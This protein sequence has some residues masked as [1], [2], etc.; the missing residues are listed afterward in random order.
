[1][2]IKILFLVSIIC[3]AVTATAQNFLDKYLTDPL[4]YT[5]IATLSDSIHSPRD[6]DFKPGTNELWIV[7]AGFSDGG[8][9]VIIFNAGLS[10]Q[11]SQYRK[12]THTSHFMGNPSAL[13]FNDEGNWASSG[14]IFS[15]CGSNCTFMGP[16]LWSG[17]TNIFARVFQNNW[18][19][20]YPLGSHLDML[21]QSPYAMGIASDSANGFWVFDGHNG[22]L[23]RYDFNVDHGPGHDDHSD[24]K[25]RRYIDILLERTI[26]VPGH[27]AKDKATGWLYIAD[28][29]NNRVIRVNT[30]TGTLGADLAPASTG[31]ETLAEY[32]A[33]T[34]AVH[35]T[36]DSFAT[37]PCGIDVYNG[38]LIIGDHDNGNIR[39][40]DITGANP[41]YLGMIATGQSGI[42]G[43]KIGPDGK[44]WFVNNTQ[45][46]V[47]R[48]NPQPV[49]DDASILNITSPITENYERNFYSPYFDNCVSS[50]VPAVTLLNSGSNTLT[51]VTINYS[52]DGTP[53]PPFPW[54]GSLA[55]GATAPVTLFGFTAT[56]GTHKIVVST[57][58]PNG[59]T[60]RNPANDSKSGSFRVMNPVATLP[61]SQTFS[62]ATFPPSGWSYVNYNPDNY[63]QRIA[64]LGGFGN[65]TG[66]LKMDIYNTPI[67]ITG[68]KD[69]FISP[70]IDLSG[71]QATKLIFSVA[72]AQYN[73]STNDTLKVLISTDCGS[74]WTVLYNKSGAT[75]A[76]SPP[77]NSGAFT[78]TSSQWR[79]DTISLAAYTGQAEALFMFMTEANDGNNIYLDDIQIP[80]IPTSIAQNISSGEL[81]VYPNPANSNVT[82]ELTPI[83]N[84]DCMVDVYNLLGEKMI[85]EPITDFASGKLNL[86]LSGLPAGNYFLRI[87]MDERISYT[88][89]TIVK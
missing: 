43:V 65:N 30:L 10:N 60:D 7:N 78:P 25:I 27:M 47:V 45:N 37:R 2:K 19:N 31:Y 40:Y 42:E 57:S 29:G 88:K 3:C 69:Y 53:Y 71:S 51:S 13:A 44:I 46:T 63:M 87:R 74:S 54:S 22:D 36:V 85:S 48:I 17:D 11:T 38:R 62:S 41:V 59:T 12:D 4:T 49:V 6:L 50:V 67:Y 82:V 68:Q 61:F 56:A 8:T 33:V 76:T 26:N 58:N 35:Q 84:H 79:S 70:R 5:T 52:V 80:S 18:L 34:G 15:T 9:N 28:N 14:E 39:I 89:L 77:Y 1:M 66:C 75:L 32:K 81:N 83:P 73:S 20:N 64:N 55:S 72:Y 16:S 24:G 21:H 23:C 86:D